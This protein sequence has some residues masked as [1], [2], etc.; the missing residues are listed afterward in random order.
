M[1][2]RLLVARRSVELPRA[3]KPRHLLEFKSRVKLGRVDAVIFDS[4]GV[5]H[6]LGVLKAVKR[7]EHSPLHVDGQRGRKALNIGLL[8]VCAYRLNKELMT[9]LVGKSGKLVLNRRTVSR[10]CSV[11][12]TRIHRRTG[13]IFSYY[14]VSFGVGV[15][16]VAG[17]LLKTLKKALRSALR[18]WGYNLLAILPLEP[19]K[20]YR[21]PPDARGSSG[22]KSHKTHA[23]RSDR[24]RKPL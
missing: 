15:H 23:E 8:G 12:L 7:A 14:A 3:V 9:L 22:L 20:V 2:R 18:V 11:N 1:S 24:R 10:S 19:L 21:A 6:Y 13:Y 5:A 4:V 16:N 17:K